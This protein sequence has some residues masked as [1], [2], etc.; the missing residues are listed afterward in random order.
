MKQNALIILGLFFLSLCKPATYRIDNINNQLPKLIFSDSSLKKGFYRMFTPNDTLNK[1][2]KI[3]I[4]RRDKFVRITIF[5]LINKS[6]ISEYPSSYFKYD[7]KIFIC[8]DGSEIISNRIVDSTVISKIRIDLESGYTN[9]SPVFQFD[10]DYKKNIK[11]NVPA[12]NP[13]DFDFN[14]KIDTIHFPLQ[15]KSR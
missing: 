6:E 10:I 7:S 15:Q 9:D 13:Y 12:H 5:R 4:S 1:Y 2:F 8:Y 11:L 3:L 14:N